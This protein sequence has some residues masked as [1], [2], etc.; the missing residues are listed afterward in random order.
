MAEIRYCPLA[1]QEHQK[2]FEFVDDVP[3]IGAQH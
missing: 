3:N 2:R 1:G